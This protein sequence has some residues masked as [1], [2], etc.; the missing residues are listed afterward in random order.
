M[1]KKIIE[2][3]KDIPEYEKLY[4]ISTVGRVK[5]ISRGPG[6]RQGRILKSDISNCNYLYVRL[7]L[8]G[9]AKRFSIHRLVLTT[10]VGQCP[11]NHECRHLDGNRQNNYLNNLMWGTHLENVQDCHRHGHYKGLSGSKN[12]MSKLNISQVK[13]IIEMSKPG[14]NGN[15]GKKLSYQTIADLFRIGRQEVSLISRRKR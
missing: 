7:Y 1:A 2:I 6:I 11:P 15:T 10:F 12:P 8:H 4:Q 13:S 9:R 5:R 3:W 14:R